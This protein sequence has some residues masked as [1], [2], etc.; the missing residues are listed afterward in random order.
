MSEGGD[1]FDAWGEILSMMLPEAKW[2]D[3]LYL[4]V[5]ATGECAVYS[6]IESRRHDA[7]IIG[8]LNDALTAKQL[9]EQFLA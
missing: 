5:P 4:F 2:V 3:V 6:T 9:K 1:V 7:R 8:S